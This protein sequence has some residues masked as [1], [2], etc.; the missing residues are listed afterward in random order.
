MRNSFWLRAALLGALAI[1]I[2]ACDDG[3]TIGSIFLHDSGGSSTGGGIP[4]GPPPPPPPPPPVA[5]LETEPNNTAA[6]ADTM[7]AAARGAGSLTTPGDVDF[8]SFPVV[9]G[10]FYHVEVFGTRLDQAG[11]GSFGNMPRITIIGTDQTSHII[12][13][14][15]NFWSWDQQDL[16]IPYFRAPATGTQFLRV[17]AQD[18]F[19][20]GGDY[21]VVVT[22][23]A[24]TTVQDES[25][26]NDSIATADPVTA[27]TIYGTK[28]AFND[29][30]FSFTTTGPTMVEFSLNCYRRGVGAVAGSPDPNGYLDAQ[31]TLFN[32][33]GTQLMANEDDHW[34]D[35]G[36]RYFVLTA[37]TYTVRVSSFSSATNTYV[38][39][40]ETFASIAETEGPT[41][42]GLND[43]AGTA[44]ASN[45]VTGYH[46]N[47]GAF[48]SDVDLWS[49]QGT[50][51][52]YVHLYWYDFGSMQGGSQDVQMEFRDATGNGFLSYNM[53]N[54]S[55][56]NLNV[57]AMNVQTTGTF[58]VRVS[59]FTNM[60]YGFRLIIAKA[61]AQEV[62]P[63]NTPAT[64]N[65]FPANNHRSGSIGTFGDQDHFTFTALANEVVSF[66]FHGPSQYWGHGLYPYLGYSPML[67][68]MTVLDSAGAQIEFY[69]MPD[70]YPPPQGT[71]NAKATCEFAFVA[72]SAG[73]YTIRVEDYNF[74]G[75]AEWRYV[76]QKR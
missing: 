57:A 72:P 53:W 5:A 20:P 43:T 69:A 55:N 67:P 30:Y 75:G 14:N 62:E 70:W 61:G 37:G 19:N 9:Q 36:L 23:L 33:A 65:T 58:H 64:S 18:T 21:A 17:E 46:G 40:F 63:N 60:A 41:A 50:A 4:G 45:F 42:S 68:Q 3:E 47:I 51:G 8:W 56:W 48:G 6:T 52:D 29:D 7:S 22:Q 15:R 49:F 59:G 73:T 76:I 2:P 13:H 24:P 25:E 66:S 35:P 44:F 27:G 28:T 10:T 38:L 74:N 1:V 32:S 54:E 12:G 16:D 71:V 34:Y 31:L 39:T 11:W 26:P